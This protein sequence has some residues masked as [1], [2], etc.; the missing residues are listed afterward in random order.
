[1][2]QTGSTLKGLLLVFPGLEAPE[3]FV[4]VSTHITTTPLYPSNQT[5][6]FILLFSLYLNLIRFKSS[7]LVTPFAN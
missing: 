4:I 7:L 1:M 2:V 5:T 6:T 3:S